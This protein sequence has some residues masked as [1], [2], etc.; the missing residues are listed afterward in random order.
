MCQFD[1]QA[2][3]SANSWDKC[4]K[5]IID[6]QIVRMKLRVMVSGAAVSVCVCVRAFPPFW[7]CLVIQLN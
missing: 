5:D 2:A 3:E 6:K 7:L 1:V 4:E